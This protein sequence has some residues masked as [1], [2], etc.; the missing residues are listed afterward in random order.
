MFGKG[1]K[2]KKKKKKLANGHAQIGLHHL[3]FDTVILFV[4]QEIKPAVISNSAILK[5]QVVLTSSILIEKE[6]LHLSLFSVI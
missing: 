6:A 5:L 2:K 1:S 4:S 3:R